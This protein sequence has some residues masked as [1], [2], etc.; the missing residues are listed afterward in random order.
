VI[1]PDTRDPPFGFATVL[2]RK[3]GEA[4][5]GRE[6]RP[7]RHILAVWACPSEAGGADED[8]V[9]LHFLQ[10]V[11]AEVELLHLSEGE[12]LD[13]DVRAPHEL[14]SEFL[15]LGPAEVERDALLVQV[16]A[17]PETAPFRAQDALGAR[18]QPPVDVR[19]DRALDADDL[20]AHHRQGQGRERPGDDPGEVGHASPFER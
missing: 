13:G 12:V 8:D 6:R 16:Q 4:R 18:W 14:L 17:M 2:A 11:V 10:L 15:A 5:V 7:E 20:G 19:V 3:R 9:G 1:G